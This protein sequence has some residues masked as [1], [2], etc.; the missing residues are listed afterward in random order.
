MQEVVIGGWTE[1]AGSRQGSIGALLLGIPSTDGLRYVGKVG[2]GFTA[3]DRQFL[4]DLLRPDARKKSPFVP[5]SDVREP[6]AHFVRPRHVG[7]VR[8]S[9]WTTAGHLRHPAWRALREDRAPTDVV[10]EA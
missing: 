1:G 3:G 7:E 9:E 8:F 10:V 2:T 6:S 4:M 5:S